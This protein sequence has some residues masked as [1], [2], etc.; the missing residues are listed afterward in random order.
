MKK[1]DFK[2]H[3]PKIVIITLIVFFLV[4]II[5]GLKSVLEMEG[6][7]EP[8]IYEESL[9]PVPQ[10]QDEM[11]AYIETAVKRAV[12]EKPKIEFSDDCDV[13][14]ESI[15]AG[16][17]QR[18]AEYVKTGVEDSISEARKVENVDFG[19]DNSKMLWVPAFLPG[20]VVSAELKYDYYKCPV[21]TDQTF[22]EIPDECPECGT[23]EGFIKKYRDNYTITLHFADEAYP[24][25]P[26]SFISRNFRPLSD[27]AISG[28][29][30]DNANGY[31]TCDSG[32]DIAYRN[33]TVQASV[34]RFTDK[35]Q[36]LKF[37]KDSD[38]K[39]E[40]T[41]IGKYSELGKEEIGF[42]VNERSEFNFIW[43]EMTLS[44]KELVLEP[45]QTDALRAESTFKNLSK[46]KLTWKSSDE[47]I[48]TVN[49]EGYV[50]AKHK[51]GKANVTAEFEFMGKMYSA[52]CVINVKVTAEGLKVSDRKL[53]LK[54]GETFTLTTKISPHKA[55]I[56]TVKWYS[57]NE[58][59]A[60]VDENG[61]VTAIKSGNADVYAVA[62]DG[63]FKATCK[64]TVVK[65]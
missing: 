35:I 18:T 16:D 21:C 20:D 32:F 62:D 43:P 39:T 53:E 56:K 12:E 29:M 11:I 22:D 30:K 1:I 63:Y 59:V 9:S 14:D 51:E 54:E 27:S 48:A 6:T 31:Y 26:S 13:N 7:M 61:T 64:V 24:L 60:T 2:K 25:S 28:I 38:F 3:L 17:A 37:I 41:F 23:T 58:D 57:D 46:E 49:H 52:T 8:N 5:W 33:I 50:S 44:S 19:E 4:G 10:T 36:S 45:G 47:T 15:C 40:L 55:T 65:Q 34:N 42:T